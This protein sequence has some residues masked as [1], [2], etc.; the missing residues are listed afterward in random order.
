MEAWQSPAE[1]TGLENQRGFR[2]PEVLRRTLWGIFSPPP[3]FVRFAHIDRQACISCQ[4]KKKRKNI[5]KDKSNKSDA[6]DDSQEDDESYETRESTDND[7]ELKEEDYI[8]SSEEENLN[9]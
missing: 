8:Y 2:P 4:L 9:K 7:S 5:N 1:C 3:I 6:S